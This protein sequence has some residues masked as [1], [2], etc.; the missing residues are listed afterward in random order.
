MSSIE[1]AIK[2][3]WHN[4]L[5]TRSIE[6]AFLQTIV[7]RINKQIPL[8]VSQASRVV[9]I[10]SRIKDRLQHL[11]PDIEALLTNPVWENSP[12]EI[13]KTRLLKIENGSIRLEMSQ[14][15]AVI[16][17][18]IYENSE[19]FE[20][21]PP[22]PDSRGSSSFTIPLTERNIITA[23]RM[24]KRYNVEMSSEIVAYYQEMMEAISANKSWFSFEDIDPASPIMQAIHAEIDI[25]NDA[26]VF[27]RQL[28][29][30]YTV[31]SRSLP[32]TSLTNVI[33]ARKGTLVYIDSKKVS[34]TEL[35][36]S[37]YQLNRLPL[38]V[39]LDEY[40]VDKSLEFLKSLISEI[41]NSQTPPSIG[42]YVR[43]DNDSGG[44]GETFNSL[45]KLHGLNAK[46]SKDT[47]I[48]IISNS[49]LPKFMVGSEWYPKS[50]ISINN[51]FK[52][53]KSFI[54]CN[55]VDLIAYYN[56]VPP[57]GIGLENELL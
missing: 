12:V 20:I 32:A 7:P 49:H 35:L 51:R 26:Q 13:K 10:L 3:V 47:S 2:T 17:Q 55:S 31:R 22:I 48:A 50:V 37:L 54:Y 23:V 38:L 1:H 18:A 28:R 42:T 4:N 39:I 29:F 14:P 52:H 44:P 45:V 41:S 30:Q 5:T 34:F 19:K 16:R 11:N 24:L 6:I 33:A 57:L 53:S 15:N 8:T 46:L 9:Y 21:S 27:D 40:A 56:T 36:Q 25:S 43:F